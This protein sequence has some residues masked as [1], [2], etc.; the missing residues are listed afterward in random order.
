MLIKHNR[1]EL[2]VYL[3]Y[4]FFF[5]GKAGF[6]PATFCAHS[7]IIIELLF[8]FITENVSYKQML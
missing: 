8:I 4:V 5:D 7:R 1:I 3:L 2:F 6:E